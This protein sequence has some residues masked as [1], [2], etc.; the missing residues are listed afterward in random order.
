MSRNHGLNVQ[1]YGIDSGLCPC[2]DCQIV[3]K[4]ITSCRKKV[5]SSLR[6]VLFLKKAVDDDDDVVVVG[7]YV[8]N[9]TFKVFLRRVWYISRSLQLTPSPRQPH[10]QASLNT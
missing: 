5:T 6:R 7:I 3:I 10:R 4:L 8:G 9:T 1:M 2:G